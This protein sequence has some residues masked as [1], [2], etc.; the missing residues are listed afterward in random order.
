MNRETSASPTFFSATSFLLPKVGR[1]RLVLESLDH[2]R[3]LFSRSG[4]IICRACA[5]GKLSSFFAHSRRQGPGWQKKLTLFHIYINLSL[6]VET[7]NLMQ[8]G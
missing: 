3:Q 5:R 2:T 4:I 7:M 6:F 1:L 8:S